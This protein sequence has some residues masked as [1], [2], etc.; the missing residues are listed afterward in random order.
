MKS[1]DLSANTLP[2]MDLGSLEEMH[3]NFYFIFHI[4]SRTELLARFNWLKSISNLFLLDSSTKAYNVASRTLGSFK[5][6]QTLGLRLLVL[7]FF[8]SQSLTDFFC[9]I[10]PVLTCNAETLKH[11]HNHKEKKTVTYFRGVSTNSC[12]NALVRFSARF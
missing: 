7:V 5:L 4:F 2:L 12:F 10:R 6:N 9:F 3:F 1:F 8:F 11:K